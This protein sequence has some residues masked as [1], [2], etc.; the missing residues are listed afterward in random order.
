MPI[1]NMQQARQMYEYG[2][3]SAPRQNYG[4]GSFVKKAVRGV[5]KIAKS[6]IGKA[7]LIG[8]GAY[9]L[10]GSSMMGG[11]GLR[12]GLGNFANLWKNTNTTGLSQI[13]G[14]GGKFSGVG[15]L[16][17]QSKKNAA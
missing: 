8:G 2:G 9:L 4:L 7:A 15:N 5:K 10:G 17:R 16:F 1:S 13:F 14:S 3:L 6:P 11:G 12:G